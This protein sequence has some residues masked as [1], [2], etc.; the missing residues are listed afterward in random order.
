MPKY[1]PSSEKPEEYAAR[2]VHWNFTVNVWDIAFITLALSLVSRETVMP[3]LVSTLTDSK[4]AIGL[5]PA[6]F[7][8][9]QYLPQLFSANLSERM[10]YKKPFVAAIGLFGERLPY[11]L[12][13]LSLYFF[14]ANWASHIAALLIPLRI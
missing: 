6:I 12:I 10:T 4:L 5:I 2:N 1:D 14:A 13:A 11:L 7:T 8:L 3:V 9:G